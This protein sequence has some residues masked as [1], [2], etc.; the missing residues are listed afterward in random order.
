MFCIYTGNTLSSLFCSPV[1]TSDYIFGLLRPEG[2]TLQWCLKE[3]SLQTPS[4]SKPHITNRLL[5][6][7]GKRCP[8]FMNPLCRLLTDSLTPGPGEW[9]VIRRPFVFPPSELGEN[10]VPCKTTLSGFF[11]KP[12]VFHFSCTSYMCGPSGAR[13]AFLNAPK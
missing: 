6:P 9:S 8:F 12:Q 2:E 3:T 10:K 4:F 5:S 13:D 11:R 1:C 7:P